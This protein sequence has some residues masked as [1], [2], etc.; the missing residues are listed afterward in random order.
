[1]NFMLLLLLLVVATWLSATGMLFLKLS[2]A[3]FRLHPLSILTNWQF[4]LAGSLYA[5][6]LAVYI[7]VLRDLP[8]SIAYPLT[9]MNYVWAA[10]LS[11]RYLKERVDAWRWTGIGLVI[12]GV[13]LISL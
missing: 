12:V 11:Q 8:I 2:S 3:K 10:I 6:S 7:I 4:I 9:S 1:M 13:A 5:A